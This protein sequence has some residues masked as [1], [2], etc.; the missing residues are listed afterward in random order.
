MKLTHKR[1]ENRDVNL[2]SKA[3]LMF[4]QQVISCIYGK[5]KAS[6]ELTFSTI[7]GSMALAC[8]DMYDVEIA[9][10]IVVPVSH[11]HMILARSG[12][13][14]TTVYRLAMAQI[15]QIEHELAEAF[16][17]RLEEYKRHYVLWDEECRSLKKSLQKAVRQKE[18]VEEARF[19]LEE[20]LKNKP[21]DPVRVRLTVTDPTPE[22]LLKELGEYSCLG[23]TS[24]E[25][26]A[27][28]E[29]IMRR[30]A[31]ISN[32]LW[33]GDNYR[34]SRV[35]TGSSDIKDPRLG[36]LVMMQPEPH[37]NI[38]RSQGKKIRATGSDA[39]ILRMDL[40]LVTKPIDINDLV[41]GNES[42]LD[43]FY[44]IQKKHL[45]SGIERRKRN[46]PRT[47]MTFSPDAK[48]R[49]YDIDNQVKCLM[50][51]G[52]ELY[53]YNDWSAR[54][55]EHTARIAAVMQAY[56][57]PDSSIITNETLESALLI[58][59]WYLNHFIVKMD[60]IIGASDSEILLNWFE[61]HLARNGSYDFSRRGIMQNGPYS[62]RKEAR[63][64]PVL[65]QLS[66]EGKIQLWEDER[67]THYVKYLAF[68]MMPSELDAK[69][70]IMSGRPVYQ[71][72][73]SVFS[74][75]PLEE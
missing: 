13:R 44:S 55:I 59:Q 17:V 35:S 23:I 48:K 21:I 4:L 63:L 64:I 41:F 56:I 29:G 33:C 25:G 37:D 34:V 20:C 74:S 46:A 32:T 9:D 68:E 51:P 28:Y 14:K 72:G 15:H 38:L 47:C 49:L 67:G 75:M 45:L 62:L 36:M 16:S 42:D 2:D 1:K 6:L 10:D 69:H 70:N 12:S 50:E 71:G 65:E 57:T 7:L 58:T 30:K 54:Y 60:M 61:S 11:F 27:L 18:G 31:A 53:H 26:S 22:A 73:Y 8:Q 19:N 66:D 43:N 39:R 40:T 52:G 24:D 3:I 5:T